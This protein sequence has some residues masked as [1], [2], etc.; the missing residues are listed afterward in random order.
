MKIHVCSKGSKELI[1][2]FSFDIFMRTHWEFVL[3]VSCLWKNH[4]KNETR[5][6]K[7]SH[8]YTHTHTMK[9]YSNKRR[10]KTGMFTMFL[11]NKERKR[12]RKSTDFFH[13]IIQNKSALTC[14]ECCSC[15][16]TIYV[17]F[18]RSP[19]AFRVD[20]VLKRVQTFRAAL[21]GFSIFLLITW[22]ETPSTITWQRFK[23]ILKSIYIKSK[24]FSL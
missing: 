4:R 20:R 15:F 6:E 8:M 21:K 11:L 23:L 2:N 18:V 17:I 24:Y 14:W 12:P 9:A 16:S 22:I 7:T 13:R 1:K 5:T 10:N 19:D 3:I